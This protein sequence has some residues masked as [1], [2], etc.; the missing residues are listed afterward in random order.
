MA[1]KSILIVNGHL[2]IGGVEKALVDLLSWID[3]DK[4]DVSLLL[5]EGEGAY[6]D[7]LPAQVKV[8]HKDMR[9]LEGPVLGN[10]WKNLRQGK[11]GNVL[12]RVINAAAKR[13]KKWFCLARPLLPVRKHYDVAVAFRPGHSAEIVAYSLRADLKICWW[14]HGSIPESDYQRNELVSIFNSF[15]RMVTVSEG[16]KCLLVTSLGIIPDHLTVIPNIIDADRID[17]LAQGDDPFEDDGRYRIVS[18]SRF[19]PEK[20]LEEAVEAASML[21]GKLDFVW[22]LIGDGCEFEKVKERVE[23]LGLKD[24]VVLT[25]SIANPYPY[26]KHADLM[27]HPS[28]IESLCISVLEAMALGIPCVVVRSIGPESFIEDSDNGFLTDKG[29]EA[30]CR[31]ISKVFELNGEKLEFIKRKAFMTV[32]SFFSPKAV[33]PLFERLIDESR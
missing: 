2:Q 28:H 20:H 19:A 33:M 5:L 9:Q 11:L 30:I 22:Y 1:R 12:Y 23:E 24:R 3:Y 4:Y 15:D 29:P 13:H 17:A 18:L 26:L 27:V 14:H 31:G 21:E 25:G 8:F 32:D 10:L 6:R 7:L 16:C